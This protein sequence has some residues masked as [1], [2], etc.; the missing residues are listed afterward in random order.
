[1]SSE[2]DS[3]KLVRYVQ[4]QSLNVEGLAIIGMAWGLVKNDNLNAIDELEGVGY[5]AFLNLDGRTYRPGSPNY[6]T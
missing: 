3:Q 6:G 1:L 5:N 4:R 2:Q